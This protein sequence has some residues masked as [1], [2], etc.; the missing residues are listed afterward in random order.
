M[1]LAECGEAGAGL[2]GVVGEEADGEGGRARRGGDPG[3]GVVGLFQQGARLVVER[4]SGGG[5][6]DSGR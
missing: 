5:R 4:G 1:A 6:R 3:T 2:L